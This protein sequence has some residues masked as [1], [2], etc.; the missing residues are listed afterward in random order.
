MHA[1]KRYLGDSTPPGDNN[2]QSRH[3]MRSRRRSARIASVSDIVGSLGKAELPHAVT[4]LGDE[5]VR[6]TELYGRVA[7]AAPSA[8]ACS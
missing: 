1:I 7:Q 2:V 4:A 6:A 8:C 5:S 3:A